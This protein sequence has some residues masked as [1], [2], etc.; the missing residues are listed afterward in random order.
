MPI[1]IERKFLVVSE[2]W[3]HAV[4][5]SEN[6]VDGLVAASDGRKVRVRLYENRATLTVKSAKN[7]L[8][9]AEFEYEIPMAEGAEL[10]A[11]H[12]GNKVCTKTRHFVEHKGFVWHVDEYTD[13]LGGIT[14][15]E[16]ELEDE[17]ADVPLPDWAGREI[18]HDPA[19]RK[20]NLL[21][22]RLGRIAEGRLGGFAP[23]WHI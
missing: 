1:E 19:Y 6:L 10:I 15:A 20:I 8:S 21:N 17:S 4:Q 2:T 5:R 12:C 16:I 13:T 7:G 3:R 9:R 14:I 18:T 22:A 11:K 23:E